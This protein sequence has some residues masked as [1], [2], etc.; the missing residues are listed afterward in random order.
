MNITDTA[1]TNDPPKMLCLTCGGRYQPREHGPCGGEEPMWAVEYHIHALGEPTRRDRA[2]RR[3]KG[4]PGA[5]SAPPWS[6]A[7]KFAGKRSSD[8]GPPPKPP[9]R[10]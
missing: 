2:A 3:K 8:Y 6:P 7:S 10:W 1:G 5:S 4:W 9:G